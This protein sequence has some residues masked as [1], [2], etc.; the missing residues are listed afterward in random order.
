MEK[1]LIKAMRNSKNS[2]LSQRL[3]SERQSTNGLLQIG[4][5]SYGLIKTEKINPHN[6]GLNESADFC[7]S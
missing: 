4:G 3:N 7:Y 6:R 2:H 5:T 1:R